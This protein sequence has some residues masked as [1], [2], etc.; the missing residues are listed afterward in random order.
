MLACLL[1]RSLS[2]MSAPVAR[3]PCCHYFCM[4]CVS[5][6]I[7]FKPQCPVCKTAVGRR[8]VAP[9]DK[10]N[11]IVALYAQLEGSLTGVQVFFALC[12]VQP[13]Y[14]LSVRAQMGC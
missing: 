3:L 6:S 7:R 1:P 8:E 5:Q 4:D 2:I 9:D 10:M 11:R 12:A 14:R 13:C